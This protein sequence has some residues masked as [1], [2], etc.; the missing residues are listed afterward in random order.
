[1]SCALLTPHC[2]HRVTLRSFL[3]PQGHLAPSL[4]LHRN[5]SLTLGDCSPVQRVRQ[6]L[7]VPGLWLQLSAPSRLCCPHRGTHFPGCSPDTCPI[8]VTFIQ[9]SLEGSGS[10]PPCPFF[11]GRKL[12]PLQVRHPHPSFH[13]F[14]LVSPLH[15]RRRFPAQLPSRQ[16]YL[17]PYLPP[18]GRSSLQ[19]ETTGGLGFPLRVSPFLWPLTRTSQSLVRGPCSP[20]AQALLSL[21]AQDGEEGATLT[22]LPA[23]PVPLPSC[24]GGEGVSP[25]RRR[26]LPSGSGSPVTHRPCLFP[27]GT[28]PL[29]PTLPGFPSSSSQPS[30]ASCDSFQYFFSAAG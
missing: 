14:F 30:Q 17:P 6:P 18:W 19:A 11:S 5:P 28:S 26:T 8:L 9:S 21:S 27:P 4:P 25:C 16:P 23:Y 7:G 13:L 22:H 24:L 29:H 15:M 12:L 10:S 1:M 3:L 20:S 2:C